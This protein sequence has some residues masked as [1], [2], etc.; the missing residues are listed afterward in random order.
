MARDYAKVNRG[1]KKSHHGRRSTTKN[2][3]KRG[4]TFVLVLVMFLLGMGG[5]YLFT[6]VNFANLEQSVLSFLSD[7]TPNF[8]QKRRVKPHFEFYSRLPQG[9][10]SRYTDFSNQAN[11]QSS[12]TKQRP[13]ATAATT[14][15]PPKPAVVDNGRYVLQ[16]GSFRLYRDAD[17]LKAKLLL[18]GY[19]VSIERFNIESVVWHRVQIG[20]YTS[21]SKAKRA[22]SSLEH[23]RMDCILKRIG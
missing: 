18:K 3:G 8:V 19:D 10:S 11:Q 21:L 4:S 13:Q 16:V 5:H 20:P 23:D 17:K 12:A 2:K 9:E 22:Q 6:R 14:S 15:T 7:K 1:K